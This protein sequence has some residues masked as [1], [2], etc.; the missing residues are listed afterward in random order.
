[1]QERASYTP[2]SG[3]LQRKMLLPGKTEGKGWENIPTDTD[4]Q[5]RQ[6]KMSDITITEVRTK[7]QLDRFIRF[8]YELYEGNEYAVPELYADMKGMFSQKKNAALEFCDYRLFTAEQDGKTVG[9]V[10]A[11]IN[12]RANETWHTRCVRFGWIDFI[13]D[14]RVSAALLNAVA[15]YGRENGMTEMQGPLGFTDFDREG[16]LIEGFDQL[17]TMSTYYNYPYY[18][19]H[20]E[21]YGMEKEIDWVERKVICP[22]S[23]PEKYVRV[24]ELVA[25]RF[26]L[27]V[28]KLKNMREVKHDEYGKRIFQ[29]I[30]DSYAPLFGY[31]RLSERQIDQMVNTYMPLVDLRMQCLVMNDNDELVGVG[32][33]MPSIVRALQKSH[34]MMF[35]FGWWHLL[36]SLKWKHE[37]GVELLLIAVRPD[38]QGKGVNALIFNDLIPIYH[39]MGF[40]WAETNP[41]L[42]DNFQSQAQ[43]EY[44]NPKVHKRRRCYKK[45]IDG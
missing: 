28:K 43:W 11:I 17:G 29:L 30:N 15:Q 38:Y 21:R 31:S 2:K 41:Q 1:M 6:A 24:A 25:K 34:G 36:K 8:N 42:E 13:D 19:E 5:K 12:H 23:I 9:R 37:S 10:A 44:L 22:E 40:K 32:L 3:F 45:H 14:E 27:R 7:K 39:Q 18:P 26:G 35:P 4:I 33:S 16:M 20:M